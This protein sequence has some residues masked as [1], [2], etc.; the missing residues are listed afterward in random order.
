MARRHRRSVSVRR[1]R[2]KRLRVHRGK[3]PLSVPPVL[4][5]PLAPPLAAPSLTP[6]PGTE[7]THILVVDDEPAVRQALAK[8]LTRGGFQVQG[9]ESGPAALKLLE[10]TRFAV[11]LCDIRMPHMT[12]LE[13]VPRAVAAD[14]DLAIIML[15]AVNDAPTATEALGSGAMDYLVKPVALQDL[16][17][18]VTRV[19]HK[20]SLA[21]EQRR[22]E[23]LIREEVASRTEEL[24][25][26]KRNLSDLTVSIA[27]ALINAMEA[28][29]VFLRGHSQRVAETAASIADDLGLDAD[30]VEQ[31]RIAG[32]LQDVGKI[33][34]RESVL[35]KPG[36]LT[37]E[38]FD[39]VKAHVRIGMEI[40]APL[41]HLARPLEF[42]AHHH[43][44]YDGGG[45][46]R[47][48]AGEAISLGGRI[49]CAADAFDALTSRRAYRDPMTPEATIAYLAQHA[50][51]LLD[52]QVFDAL[53]RV[54]KRHNTLVYIDDVHA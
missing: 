12:G 20:R 25:Q 11:M 8:S 32:R 5:E 45:Y 15:T 6:F 19:L 43:E 42:V 49:L 52:P 54:V 35:N 28:K 46:P 7:A 36:Q 33:G 16:S 10:R 14:E 53:V 38:E 40:L 41:K 37:P 26:E 34:I 22:V 44:H 9:A 24:E 47:Q 4:T 31:V 17:N 3:A 1:D 23:R 50:G 30:T 51:K 48:L 18:A 13:L 29:D 27:E 2:G 39:H 21:M